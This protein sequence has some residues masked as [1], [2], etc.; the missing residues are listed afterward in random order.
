MESVCVQFPSMLGQHVPKCNTV[1]FQ[2]TAH[3]SVGERVGS[4]FSLRLVSHAHC[5]LFL[6]IQIR[7]NLSEVLLAT[8]NI[9]FT[10]YKRL[11]GTGPATPARPPRVIEDR[12]S[13]RFSLPF[14]RGK[15]QGETLIA[16]VLVGEV[17]ALVH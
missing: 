12:D 7:Q 14:W 17:V 5:I 11:K 2:H 13:V 4:P 15:S 6:F 9:L 10:Q 3:Q 16:S 1:R 8:M